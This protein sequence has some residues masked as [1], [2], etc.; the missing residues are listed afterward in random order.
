M[1]DAVVDTDVVSFPLKRDTRPELYQ[2]HLLNR[3]LVVTFMTVAEL[4]RSALTRQW[5]EGRETRMPEQL[6]N[7]VTYPFEPPLCLKWAEVTA[8][9]DA[10][11]HPIGCADAW[12]AATAMLHEIPLITHNRRDF[13][14]VPGLAI[15]S[16]PP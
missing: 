3:R 14:G 6:R 2:P 7:F 13:A 11:G 12:I 9:A 16:Q 10:S 4:E 15:I 1:P 5:G 8:A